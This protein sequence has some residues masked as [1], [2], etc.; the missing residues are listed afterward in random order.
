MFARSSANIALPSS[1]N[2]CIQ[3][4]QFLFT[5]SQCEL[6]VLDVVLLLFVSWL[7]YI[8]RASAQF[9]SLD[10]LSQNKIY[11]ALY[12]NDI[13]RSWHWAF[14]FHHP[15]AD[16][17]QRQTGYKIHATNKN[18][19]WEY[20]CVPQSIGFSSTLTTIAEIGAVDKGW[21]IGHL[22][23]YTREVQL[24]IPR[25]AKRETVFNC[26][27]WIKAA[28]KY[29]S[30]AGMFVHCDDVDKLENEMVAQAALVDQRAQTGNNMS[31]Y[32]VSKNA[33]AVSSD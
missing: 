33:R 11:L 6:L 1:I 3:S 27:V 30:D 7:T 22:N 12:T 13:G 32:F 18:G 2:P 9:F 29:L 31:T 17:G 14:Y 15:N 23:H 4:L 21:G 26:R 28:I 24:T 16:G 5:L 19:R 8:D 20:Q 10:Q 25:Y